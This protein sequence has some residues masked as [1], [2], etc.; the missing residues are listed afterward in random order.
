[1]HDVAGRD[2]AL[3]CVSSERLHCSSLTEHELLLSRL[4]E[5]GT[6]L[7]LAESLLP[8]SSLDPILHRQ[9]LDVQVL[10]MFKVVPVAAQMEVP[11]RRLMR[12]LAAAERL[13]VL[14]PAMAVGGLERSS[15]DDCDPLR[16]SFPATRPDHGSS[17][18][19]HHPRR[20]VAGSGEIV[21]V[22]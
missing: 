16:A 11:F 2:G 15:V 4:I 20:E 10:L 19:A 7:R 6:H 3:L 8:F 9:E 17:E 13:D 5:P 22:G 14:L 1:M 18:I 12:H 21:T